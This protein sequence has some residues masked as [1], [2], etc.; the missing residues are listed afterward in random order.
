M[1]SGHDL[2]AALSVDWRGSPVRGR[3]PGPSRSQSGGVG[4]ARLSAW[5]VTCSLFAAPEILRGA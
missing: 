4:V 5:P 1:P 2:P 3:G